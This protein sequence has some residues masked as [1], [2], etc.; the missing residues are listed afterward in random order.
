MLLGSLSPFF[1]VPGVQGGG[2]AA[3]LLRGTRLRGS[4]ADPGP[5]LGESFPREKILLCPPLDPPPKFG[6]PPPHILRHPRTIKGRFH[7]ENEE[8][9]EGGGV[10]LGVLGL[11]PWQGPPHKLGTP[12]KSLGEVPALELG[13]LRGFWGPPTPKR[14]QGWTQGRFWNGGKGRPPPPKI[15]PRFPPLPQNGDPQTLGQLPKFLIS[16]L[17]SPQILG[18]PLLQHQPA[19]KFRL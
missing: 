7:P 12:Q 6:G 14:L 19:P 8:Q 3:E 13:G 16:H 1:P 15:T 4:A 11:P 10:A 18:V 17:P 2:G 9:K 5:H